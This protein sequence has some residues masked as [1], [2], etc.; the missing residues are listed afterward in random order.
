MRLPTDD[1]LLQLAAAARSGI[2]DPDQ[3][4]FQVPWHHLPSPAFE[5]QFLLHCWGV[6]GAWSPKHWQLGLAVIIDGY[7]VG[8]QD[9]MAKDFAIT[10]TVSSG[11]WLAREYHGHGYGTEM[12]GGMI[13]LAFD[14][15]G[16]AVAESGY[17]VGNGPSE[18]VSEKLGYVP[19][20]EEVFAVEGKRMVERK[21]RV[22]RDEW[23]R[24]IVPATIEGLEPCLKL[25]GIGDLG[26]EEWATF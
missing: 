12:R 1:D 16:A 6:R 19:N 2:T 25:F 14:G 5:R 11:S 18:R 10:R 4:V 8:M 13:A 26:P 20:G 15:L 21:L 7:A 23:K 24:D 22:T 3:I 17:F 9:I